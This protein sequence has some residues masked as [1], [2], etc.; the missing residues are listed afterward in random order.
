M[1]HENPMIAGLLDIMIP[2]V[3]P[4]TLVQ[5]VL[6]L[7]KEEMRTAVDAITGLYA[8]VV[9]DPFVHSMTTPFSRR[10]VPDSIAIPLEVVKEKLGPVEVVVTLD[11]ITTPPTVRP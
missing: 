3:L 2:I 7:E 5:I 6:L 10:K 11:P 9:T 1:G 8:E 4:T